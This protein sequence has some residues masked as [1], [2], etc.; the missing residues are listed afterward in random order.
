MIDQSKNPLSSYFRQPAIYLKIPSLGRWWAPGSIDLPSNQEIAIYPMTAR[1]EVAIRTP[2]ALLNGQAVVDVIQS[3]CPNIKDAWQMPSVDTDAILISI[4]IATYG[5]RMEVKTKCSKCGADNDH[6]VDLGNTLSGITCPEFDQITHYEDLKIKLKPQNYQ[7]I[8]KAGMIAYEEQKL[9]GY[10]SNETLSDE[11]KL[12]EISKNMK[13]IA[14][15]GFD[16]L[17][18]CTEYVELPNGQQ[19]N[20]P[21]YLNEF[22]NNAKNDL[23]TT[24]QTFLSKILQEHKI[25]PVDLQC[26]NCQ[27]QYQAELNFDFSNFFVKGF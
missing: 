27:E 16:N 4:R 12:S 19:V 20:D 5:N 14:D 1:D 3:C 13:R 18:N 2:D 8:N 10:L 6:D 15:L 17:I 26:N 23:V 25:K 22:F 9:L 24:I 21:V 11:E 7:S